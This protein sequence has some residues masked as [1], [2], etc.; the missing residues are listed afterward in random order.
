MG[1]PARRIDG[2]GMGLLLTAGSIQQTERPTELNL[3]PDSGINYRKSSRRNASL[4]KS[5]ALGK[6]S[7]RSLRARPAAL[8]ARRAVQEHIRNIFLT[9][10]ARRGTKAEG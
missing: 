9:I 10:G 6:R 4:A 2:D 5:A 1:T 3:G 8:A 7:W